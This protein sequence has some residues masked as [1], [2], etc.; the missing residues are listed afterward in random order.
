MKVKIV[1]VS[2]LSCLFVIAVSGCTNN[3]NS[4]SMKMEMQNTIRYQINKKLQAEAP[5][6]V[7]TGV[8]LVQES[9]INNNKFIGLVELNNGEQL[10]LSVTVDGKDYIW[11]VIE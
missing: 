8:T 7:A 6:V 4:S 9:N 1:T 3:S 5:D 2:V 10:K 11:E